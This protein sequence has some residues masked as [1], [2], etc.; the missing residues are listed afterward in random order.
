MNDLSCLACYAPTVKRLKVVAW[1]HTCQVPG[2][3]ADPSMIFVLED[4]DGLSVSSTC[5]RHGKRIQETLDN[6]P[7]EHAKECPERTADV[8]PLAPMTT[9][10]YKDNAGEWR[11]RVTGGNGEIVGASS[12]GFFD[13]GGARKNIRALALAIQNFTDVTEPN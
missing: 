6:P 13:E 3:F 12:E 4:A 1:G 10:F 7:Q 5:A 9:T 8:V 2:C 11:W